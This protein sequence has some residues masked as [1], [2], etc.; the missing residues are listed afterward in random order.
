MSLLNNNHIYFYCKEGDE[1]LSLNYVS[2][3]EKAYSQ[4]HKKF[5]SYRPADQE[6]FDKMKIIGE[7]LKLTY[8]KIL[9]KAKKCGQACDVC[10]D[11]LRSNPKNWECYYLLANALWSM[12]QHSSAIFYM[13]RAKQI[14]P[15]NF[16]ITRKLEFYYEETNNLRTYCPELVGDIKRSNLLYLFS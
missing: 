13:N 7:K 14:N 8:A 11:V 1:F 3:A 4:A 12:A 9:T 2:K 15:E 5:E 16:E 6:Q 10:R